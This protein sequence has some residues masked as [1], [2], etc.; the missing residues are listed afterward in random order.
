MTEAERLL[1]ELERLGVSLSLEDDGID[2][3]HCE[4]VSRELWAEAMASTQ[5]LAILLKIREV[6]RNIVG[7]LNGEHRILTAP[8]PD[9][10][11]SWEK[12]PRRIL[13]DKGE[14]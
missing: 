1:H 4:G 12:M 14:D 9:T 7:G 10:L 13:A 2:Y 11:Q 6:D 5:K 3:L 8:G